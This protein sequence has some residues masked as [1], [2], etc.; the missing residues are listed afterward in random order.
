MFRYAALNYQC[1]YSISNGWL[2]VFWSGFAVFPRKIR[3][4]W[5][6]LAHGWVKIQKQ[7]QRK[8][9]APNSSTCGTGDS[10]HAAFSET[11]HS[12][13]INDLLLVANLVTEERSAESSTI[14]TLKT[15]IHFPRGTPPPPSSGCHGKQVFSLFSRGYFFQFTCLRMVTINVTTY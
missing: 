6:Q 3:V 8:W 14:K 4:I 11:S 7:Q 5:A 13:M 10:D 1:Q 9:N 15:S 12:G 2:T